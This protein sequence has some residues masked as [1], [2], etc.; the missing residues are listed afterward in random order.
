MYAVNLT[1]KSLL[2]PWLCHCLI[3]S[4]AVQQPQ[5]LPPLTRCN[6]GYSA[7]NHARHCRLTSTKLC[8]QQGL[9]RSLDSEWL[10]S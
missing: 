9:S 5:G 7:G 1:V 2:C 6:L 4:A 3:C 8:N 10:M